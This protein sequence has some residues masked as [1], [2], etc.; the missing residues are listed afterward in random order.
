MKA[1]RV[2]PK[3]VIGEAGRVKQVGEDAQLQERPV[4]QVPDLPARLQGGRALPDLSGQ[5]HQPQVG[6]DK[7]LGRRVVQ[8]AGDALALLLLQGEQLLRELGDLA[9]APP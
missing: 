6:R 2:A 1:R 3:T 5:P 4:E 9:L 7:V 8:L